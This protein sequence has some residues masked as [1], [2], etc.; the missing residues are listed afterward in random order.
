LE[1]ISIAAPKTGWAELPGVFEYEYEG[2]SSM[3]QFENLRVIDV[4]IQ[5]LL[6]Y[7]KYNEDLNGWVYTAEQCSCLASLLPTSLEH[8]TIRRYSVPIY[9]ALSELFE[10]P[11]F[12][13]HL[14][15]I[16]VSSGICSMYC[17]E[18]PSNVFVVERRCPF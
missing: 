15:T 1:V 5:M 6:G 7:D 10:S 11:R 9:K 4:E 17:W 3:A 8:L 13:P 14:K 12:P 18:S 16:S 2:L